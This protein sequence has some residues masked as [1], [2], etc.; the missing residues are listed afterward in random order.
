MI[1]M[2]EN[3]SVTGMS[4]KVLNVDGRQVSLDPN[5]PVLRVSWFDAMEFV[6]RLNS[7]QDEYL[8]R[9]PASAEWEFGA[10]AGSRTRFFFGD[11]PKEMD[12][13][14]WTSPNSDFMVH[15]VARLRP[16]GF[17][18][19]DV[20]GNIREWTSDLFPRAGSSSE[21]RVVRGGSIHLSAEHSRC[22]HVSGFD[23]EIRT[24]DLG[25]RLVRVPRKP[26]SH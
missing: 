22:S 11:D 4:S 17:G 26:N 20:H 6:S 16:N 21:F 14:G 24:S 23:P 10:R 15:P 19:Y 9:L 12:L 25:F 7:A 18:L 2:G 3:P 1:V 13:Y 5:H 8:Y